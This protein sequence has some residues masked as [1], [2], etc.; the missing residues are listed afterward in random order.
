M[1]KKLEIIAEVGQGY[2]GSIFLIKN[3]IKSAANSGV[4]SLKFQMVFADELST[5]NYKH[6]KLFKKLEMSYKEW[7]LVSKLA[8]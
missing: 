7:N 8:S 4:E 6:Y 1:L 5:K 3:L 2:E